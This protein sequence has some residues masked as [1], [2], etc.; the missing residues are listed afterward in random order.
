MFL[1]VFVCNVLVRALFLLASFCFPFPVVVHIALYMPDKKSSGHLEAYLNHVEGY[2]GHLEAA[3]GYPE[4]DLG[5]HF[6]AIL[7]SWRSFLGVW[8][9]ILGVLFLII[10][11]SSWAVGGR[12]G[13]PNRQ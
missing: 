1:V 9:P 13:N 8:R 7:G 2:S 5:G 6:R 11:G 4:A 10:R 12:S 3:L